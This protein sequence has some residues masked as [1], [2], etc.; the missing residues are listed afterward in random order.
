MHLPCCTERFQRRA[1]SINRFIFSCA[2]GRRYLVILSAC[3][4]LQIGK[5]GVLFAVGKL[6]PSHTI[7]I[8]RVA[9]SASSDEL[10]A[11]I[12]LFSGT[13]GGGR[14]LIYLSAC[15]TIK[16]WQTG[17]L[18]AVGKVPPFPC[19]MQFC[20]VATER[21]QRRVG[22]INRFVFQLRKRGDVTSSPSLL[23][24]NQRSANKNFCFAVGK[25]AAFPWPYAFCYVAPSASSDD[26]VA[27]IASFSAAQEGDVTL[28]S[29]PLV[30]T[31]R[32]ANR[33]FVCRR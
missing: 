1:G 4:C 15:K 8:Y 26:L 13:K 7:C 9:K 20:Y 2:R 14:Y 3:K 22:S 28:S 21:F 29:S 6:F 24:N 5:T 30:N 17:I 25:S 33:C 10:E 23:V 19:P 27:S 31:Y 16:D 11:S 32:S 12:A 18:F